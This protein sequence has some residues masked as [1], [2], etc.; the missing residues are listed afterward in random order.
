MRIM[1][2]L[3]STQFSPAILSHTSETQYLGAESHIM[4]LTT[5]TELLC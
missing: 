5:V 1:R 2:M 3:S 4:L